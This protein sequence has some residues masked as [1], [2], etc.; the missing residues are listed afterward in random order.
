MA[1]E[2]SGVTVETFTFAK[3]DSDEIKAAKKEM[4]KAFE[5]IQ[6]II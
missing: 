3:G 1:L 2:D 5:D 6:N 4:R